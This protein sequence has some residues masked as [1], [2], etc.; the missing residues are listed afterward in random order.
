MVKYITVKSINI[1]NLGINDLTIAPPGGAAP[2]TLAINQQ[3]QFT[4][5]GGYTARYG[6]VL[7]C[8]LQ[9]NLH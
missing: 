2:V 5:Q 6:T 3:A 1:Q 4:V 7:S 9:S 8:C